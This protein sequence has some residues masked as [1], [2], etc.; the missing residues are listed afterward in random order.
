MI[1]YNQATG[2]APFI[3]D[4]DIM[5]LLVYLDAAIHIN[6]GTSHILLLSTGFVPVEIQSACA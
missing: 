3:G 4:V 2:H 6:L 5:Y 1:A